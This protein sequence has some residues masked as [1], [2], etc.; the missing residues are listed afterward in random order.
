[1]IDTDIRVG[2]AGWSYDDWK[3]TVYP[4]GA[5]SKFDPLAWLKDY[6][7]TIEINSTFYHPQKASVVEKWI[8]RVEGNRR[9]LFTVKLWRHFTHDAKTLDA[10]AVGSVREMLTPLRDAERLGAVLCQFPWSFR[11]N[12]ENSRY[13]R[14]LFE[15]F[16]EFPLALEVRHASWGTPE[17][18][19]WLRE[20]GV[21]FCNIDQ[22]VIGASLDR[23]G[24]ATSSI[25]YFR[26][27]GQNIE[28][29]FREDADVVERYDYLYDADELEPWARAIER[30]A[31]QL[32]RLFIIFNNHYRG[33]APANALEMLA[34]L[35]G[36]TVAVPLPLLNAFPRLK[37][38]SSGE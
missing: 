34:R 25:G 23:T 22:P 35:T 19:D 14:D 36:G 20:Q 1:V 3:G 11:G 30:I 24:E 33:Q 37:E 31:P 17:V 8:A 9:F 32:S 26:L 29:W 27:H 28:N 21:A 2:P 6:F 4:P 10:D 15:V 13:L 38:I 7:D 16:G 5:G 18:F 12:R